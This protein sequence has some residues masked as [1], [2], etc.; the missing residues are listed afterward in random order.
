VFR[1]IILSVVYYEWIK[2]AN[3]HQGIYSAHFED[4][5]ILVAVWKAC[6]LATYH[7]V[8]KKYRFFNPIVRN[9]ALLP[10]PIPGICDASQKAVGFIGIDAG[11]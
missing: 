3:E 7:F 6:L 2:S 1:I 5:R 8:E 11:K 10:V 4:Y 9:Q